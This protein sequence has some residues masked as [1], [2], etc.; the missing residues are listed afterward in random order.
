MA[1]KIINLATHW[2]SHYECERW[3]NV[4][5]PHVVVNKCFEYAALASSPLNGEQ[6]R[7]RVLDCLSLLISNSPEREYVGFPYE[8]LQFLFFHCW[9][10]FWKEEK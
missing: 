6:L 4:A 9:D 3:H 10:I 8:D 7:E 5:N 2:K 1:I